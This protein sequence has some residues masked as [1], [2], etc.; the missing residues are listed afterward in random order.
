[1][2]VWASFISDPRG[3]RAV[4]ESKIFCSCATSFYQFC[5]VDFNV[6]HSSGPSRDQALCA[7]KS[8]EYELWGNSYIIN[9]SLLNKKVT[10]L[11]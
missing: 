2:P 7:V 8:Y 4:K 10:N 9:S 5:H 11:V 1:M 6:R 3:V